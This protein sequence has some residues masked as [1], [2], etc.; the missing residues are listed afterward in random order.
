MPTTRYSVHTFYY[1]TDYLIRNMD[2]EDGIKQKTDSAKAK[3]PKELF[4][5]S[6][7]RRRKPIPFILS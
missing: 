4:N 7:I 2:A 3:I 6:T 1:I 5:I